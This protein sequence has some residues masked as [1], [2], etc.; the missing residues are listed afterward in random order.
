MDHIKL[1]CDI[2]ELNWIFSDS[3]GTGTFL[4]KIVAMVA[5]HMHAQ[6]C[7]VYLFDP[8][9]N[10]LVLKATFGLN[11]THIDKIELK[12]GEGLTGM[13]LKELRPICESNSSAHP[14]YKFFNG[15]FEE[16][17]ESFLAVP[18]LRGIEKIGVLVVQRKQDFPF[19]E[20]D[21]I[22]M[23]AVSNQLANIV[24]NARALLSL[25]SKTE[26]SLEKVEPALEKF[27]KGKIAS[28]GFAY[29]QIT[30]EE[31]N[32]AL[33]NF[34][35]KQYS[36]VY[37]LEE[38]EKAISHTMHQLEAFQEHVEEQ[39]SDV[40][41]LIF[42]AHLLFLQD[43]QFIGAIR[44]LIMEG[45]NPPDAI[46][47]VGLKYIDLLSTNE[48]PYFREKAD[49]IKDL[50][51]RIMHNM[52]SGENTLG[53]YR[54]RIV[55]ARELLPS[56][57]LKISIEGASGVILVGGGVTSHLSI[58]ARSLRMPM[59]IADNSRLLK[60]P[61]TTRILMDGELGNIYINPN[62]EIIAT[63]EIRDKARKHSR[64]VRGRG[65]NRIFTQDNV[66]IQL[67][68][69]I[70]LLTDLQAAQEL[71]CEG[72]GLY[73]SEFPFIIRNNFPSEQ[74]Q[75]VVYRKLVEGMP[76]KPIVFR[77]LDIGGD[78]VLSYYDSF[79]EQNPFLGMRS[80]RFTLNKRDVFIQQL[81]AILRAGFDAD[82]RIMFPMISSL[83]ELH[84]ARALVDDCIRQLGCEGDRFNN[85]PQIGMM[86]EIPSVIE[87]I[88]EFAHVVDFFSIGTNDLIQY[89]LAVDRTNEKVSHLYLPHHPAVLRAMDRIVKAAVENDTPVS[90]CGDMAHNSQYLPFLIG[91]GLK[92]FSI[93]PFFIPSVQKKIEGID[94]EQARNLAKS[95]LQTAEI[96]KIEKILEL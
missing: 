13:A 91:I 5:R 96:S 70:N 37:T 17:Y 71:G 68:S 40:A 7:S 84:S 95:V 46:L 29:G 55:V 57:I 65:K 74:E 72:I 79:K 14:N 2:G 50:T 93:D 38:F 63:F 85:K 69:N 52:I 16:N 28:T 62:R 47:S 1:L 27:L 59:V 42:A 30:V 87:L 15:S 4:Q 23:R 12:H 20:T 76:K 6:V 86:V 67:L 32:K 48:N 41:S 64:A 53:N 9:K 82:L 45:F 8:A 34:R 94:T 26:N 77:T 31:K 73:R 39:L 25:N 44:Q 80:I 61:E 89:L 78:K 33:A 54:D 22:A 56:D 11:P 3:K 75:Y 90:V 43:E 19:T 35:T 36:R 49:D 92:S 51:L 83:D 24:E 21:I 88:D 60:L 66:R 10:K 81:R 18:M 58:L